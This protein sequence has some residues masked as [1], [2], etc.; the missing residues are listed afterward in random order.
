MKKNLILLASLLALSL[1]AAE[2]LD[3][4][5]RDGKLAN[6]S[7]SVEPLEGGGMVLKG[8][9][10]FSYSKAKFPVRDQRN[11]RISFAVQGYASRI[12]IYCYSNN[13]LAGTFMERI[14]NADNRK[15]FEAVFA[16]PQQI[17]GKNIDSFRIVFTSSS[18]LKIY[19]VEMFLEN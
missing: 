13:R 15:K 7:G 18:G 3:W 9:N 1:S 8:Q 10:C 14:P 19:Q 2:S 6:W 5:T 11:V 12:G 17:K 16:I 4:N